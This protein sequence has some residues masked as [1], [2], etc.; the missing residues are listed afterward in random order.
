MSTK[1]NYLY[2]A[3]FTK[4]DD[5]GYS[6]EFPDL[7][8]CFTCGDDIEEALSMAKEALE[9]HLYCLEKDGDAIPSPSEVKPS[10]DSESV[11]LVSVFMPPVRDEMSQ[12]RVKKTLTI[13]KWL[14]D[15]GNQKHIN[16]SQVLE[17]ALLIKAGAGYYGLNMPKKEKKI[18][19]NGNT[20]RKLAMS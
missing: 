5:G 6:I 13:P 11:Y 4:E 9:L 12:Q 19:T 2:P 1:N 16:F 8:G 15:Y 3:L 7:P 18:Q 10:S 17:N 20:K 14:N